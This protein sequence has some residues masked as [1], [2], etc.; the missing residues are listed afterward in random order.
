MIF[1]FKNY[2]RF[3]P[4]SKDDPNKKSVWRL[5]LFIFIASVIAGNVAIVLRGMELQNFFPAVILVLMVAV[6]TTPAYGVN[7]VVSNSMLVGR[8]QR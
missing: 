4:R 5:Y 8:L 2:I 3:N 1:S 6:A 7:T